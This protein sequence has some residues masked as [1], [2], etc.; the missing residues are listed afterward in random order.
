MK[1]VEGKIDELKSIL[2][3]FGGRLEVNNY[4]PF[5]MLGIIFIAIFAFDAFAATT[6]A[7]FKDVYDFING[8]ATGY[9]GRAIA[10]TGG[11]VGM[12]SGA[13]SGRLLLGAS[14]VGLA[15]FGVLGPTIVN[16]IFSSATI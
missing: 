11:V 3:N 9:L 8:A 13:V 16:S 6:G 14:G 15:A 7:E 4:Q 2:T 5:K 12:I 1:R 10:I